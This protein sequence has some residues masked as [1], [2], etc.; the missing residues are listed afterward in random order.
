M[1]PE[2]FLSCDWGTSRFRLRLAEITSGSVLAETTSG[3]GVANIASA[4]APSMRPA[5]FGQ[6]VLA[7]IDSLSA[8]AGKDLG[9]L[10]L[11]ISGMASSTL[12]WQE[13]PY[14]K[15][16]FALSGKHALWRELPPLEHRS[17]ESR[18][19]LLSGVCSND[20][21]MRGEET[22]LLGA[23]RFAPWVKEDARSIVILPGT[24]SKHLEIQNQVLVDFR[25]YMTGELFDIL[26]KHSVLRHSL[27][28]EHA[29]STTSSQTLLSTELRKAFAS[30]VEV[31]T[32]RPLSNALFLVRTCCASVWGAFPCC[33]ALVVNW[34]RAMNWR[35]RRCNGSRI[36]RSCRRKM[37]PAWPPWDR[38]CY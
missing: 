31:G 8:Q 15:L 26:G 24:H 18:V 36:S 35:S 21:V 25:T 34:P 23:W 9:S 4:T 37:S 19:F 2:L 17:G 38:P 11:V 22:E 5:V 6:E 12:G 20:D 28:S 13:L 30:G 33:C 7:G 29:L 27:P 3:A 32:Q 10:P 1:T 16:P 14:A